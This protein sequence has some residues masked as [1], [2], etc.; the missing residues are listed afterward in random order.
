MVNSKLKLNTVNSKLQL[1]I[2]NSKFELNT[3]NSKLGF[4]SMSRGNAT[5][6]Y[7]SLK[8]K[9]ERGFCCVDR[10]ACMLARVVRVNSRMDFR[11]DSRVDSRVAARVASEVYR[12]LP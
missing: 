11:V 3:I 1:N 8:G 7:T 6:Q 4:I 2:I 12:P 10:L 5:G 9:G